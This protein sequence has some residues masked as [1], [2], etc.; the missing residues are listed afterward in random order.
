MSFQTTYEELKLEHHIPLESSELDGFQTT[1][2]E[3]KR[4][5]DHQFVV[6][7]ECFQTTYEELKP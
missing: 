1:Y 2:E 3:L 6:V 5:L 4:D 7:H